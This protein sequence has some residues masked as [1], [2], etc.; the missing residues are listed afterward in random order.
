VESRSEAGIARSRKGLIRTLWTVPNRM[1][2]A[3][4]KF[5]GEEPDKHVKAVIILR[6][7][8]GLVILATVAFAYPGY[9]TPMSELVATNGNT[10]ADLVSAL[11]LADSSLTSTLYGFSIFLL[12]IFVFA[13]PITVL[14]R[15]GT[16]L[17]MLRHMCIPLIA[18]VLFA[19]LMGLIVGIADLL[20]LLGNGMNASLSSNHAATVVTGV[21]ELLILIILFLAVVPV[22]AVWYI[23]GIYLAAVDVFRADDAHPL[24]APF[25]TTV[26]SWA[27]AGIAWLAGGPTGV[28]HS[29]RWPLMLGGPVGVSAIS[30]GVCW[31]LWHNHHDVLFRN[32]PAGPGRRMPRTAASPLAGGAAQ[33]RREVIIV[34]ACLAAL[35]PLTAILVV[36][37]VHLSTPSDA[38]GPVSLRWSYTTGNFVDSPA[39]AGGT[40]YIGSDDGKVYALDAAT[41]DLRWTYTTGAAVESS[42]AVAAGT[43]YIGSNDDRVY[44]LNAATGHLRWTYKTGS[45]V[46]SSPAVEGGTVYIGSFDGKVYALDAV[47]GRLRWTYTT[48][49]AIYSS[50]AAV[51]GTV[52]VGSYDGNVYAL[53]AA[54]GR[55]RWSYSTGDSVDS[56]PTVAGGTVYIGSTNDKVYALDAATGRIRWTYTTGSSIHSSPAATDTTVYIG[57]NDDR[58]YALNAATGRVRWTYTTGGAV[59]SSP[60]VSHGIVY[61]G[62]FDGN[63]YALNAVTGRPR[64]SYATGYYV[65]SR[66]AVAGS[67][68]Y[69]GSTGD[70][71]YAL[72][73]AS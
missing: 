45:Y 22:I 4:G 35:G 25:A 37:G 68:V 23:K 27:L 55:P 14:T 58:V 28:P 41:G 26:V 42:P 18:F 7:A 67:T 62:S 73:S 11:K 3:K 38:S 46:V 29:L 13:V 20:N 19:A 16:R 21:A 39:V 6:S 69:V 70:E 66:P 52:Y 31:R 33:S 30:V 57:S 32:G 24:L 2:E 40:V 59:E 60:T 64:W 10:P 54:T 15:S 56:D 12:C 1:L 36:S 9:T 65:Y 63:V 49:A 61:I 47:T 51:G 5:L 8:C 34:S 17:A 48:G 53:N 50:P 71:V 44:A 72:T 43:V